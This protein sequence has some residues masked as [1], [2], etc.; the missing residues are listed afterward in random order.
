MQIAQP[1]QERMECGFQRRAGV[2]LARLLVVAALQIGAGAERAPGAC[3]DQA[4]DLGLPV[5]DGIERL[6]ETAEHVDRDRVHH[7][8]VVELQ[9]GHRTVDI[10]RDVFELHL[11][12]YEL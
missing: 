4:T 7:L 8:L 1:P 11:F 2:A 9:D 3:D 5:V 12:P 6:G 10:E